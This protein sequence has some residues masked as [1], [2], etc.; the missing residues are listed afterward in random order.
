MSQIGQT[1]AMTRVPE[2]N[3]IRN[4]IQIWHANNEKRKIH[5]WHARKMMGIDEKH[6]KNGKCQ[7]TMGNRLEMMES[8][9]VRC[10]GSYVV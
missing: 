2:K 10:W 4:V 3:V 6:G 1:L 8:D 5:A 7:E 9:E